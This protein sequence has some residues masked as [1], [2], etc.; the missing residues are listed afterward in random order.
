MKILLT[1]A[2]YIA[3]FLIK[4]RVVLVELCETVINCGF[5]EDIVG[6]VSLFF[7]GHLKLFNGGERA[8]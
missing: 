4:A 6:I 7:P 5:V 1:K 3:R 8:P 2:Q